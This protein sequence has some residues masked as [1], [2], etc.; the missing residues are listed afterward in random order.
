MITTVDNFAQVMDRK[1]LIR[2]LRGGFF[3]LLGVIRATI[4]LQSDHV[5]H[6]ANSDLVSMEY[7]GGTQYV[8]QDNPNSPMRDRSGL[9]LRY[10]RGT[11]PSVLGESILLSIL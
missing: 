8:L 6:G 1:P 11:G 5:A 7:I 2:R 9:T 4:T 3:P 10:W